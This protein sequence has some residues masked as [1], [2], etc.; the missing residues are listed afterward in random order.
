MYLYATYQGSQAKR[1]ARNPIPTGADWPEIE[2]QVERILHYASNL[3]DPGP[4]HHQ[5][6]AF[7]AQGNE[8]ARKRVNGD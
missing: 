4:D 1:F 2:G 5:L 8:I 6:I 7:D 3:D